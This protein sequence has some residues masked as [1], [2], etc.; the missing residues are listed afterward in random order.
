MWNRKDIK[1][2]GKAAFIAN[3]WR[4]VLVALILAAVLGGGV[5]AGGRA[6][7]SDVSEEY[8][9]ELS[10]PE[11]FGAVYDQ[12][13]DQAAAEAGVSR[14]ETEPIFRE[15]VGIFAL[16]VLGAAAAAILVFK[17]VDILLFNPIE[18]GCRNFFVSNSQENAQ[19]DEL[20]RAFKPHWGHNVKTMLLRDIFLWLWSTLLV[21]PGIVKSYSYRMVPYILAEHPEMSGREVITLSRKMM[22]GHKWSAFVLDISFLG[23]DILSG[24]TA[25]ILGVFYVE[26]YKAA[27]NAEL[28]QAI[29]QDWLV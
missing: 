7:Y 4:S 28:Y 10:D 14:E 9:I 27:T 5:A 12:L 29:K 1:E 16:I 22:A 13:I 18:V 20:G 2:K 21:V 25:G 17:I 3:Y 26:P 23:W 24:M 6:A 8:D 15:V 11:S 19:L